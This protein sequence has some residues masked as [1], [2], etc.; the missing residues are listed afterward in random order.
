MKKGKLILKDGHSF[1][2]RIFG[3]EASSAGEV[4]FSTGMVGYPESLTDPSFEGQLLTLTYPLIGNYGIP[5]NQKDKFGIHNDFESSR[6]HIS[7]LVV[8][9]YSEE[10][11]HWQAKKS[12]SDYLKEAG[13]PGIT[14]IDTRALTKILREK[15]CMLGKIVVEDG[16][17]NYFDPNAENL[18]PRVSIAKKE[19]YEAGKKRLIVIDCGVKNNTLRH[20]LNRGITLIRVPWN[21]DFME[22]EEKFDGVFVSNGPGNPALL[23]ETVNIIR[24]CFAKKVPTFGICLGNQLMGLAAGAK[25]YKLKYGHR[26]QNQPCINTETGNCY[27]TSQN[28]GFA[29][30]RKTLPK[31]WKVWFE[32][33]NDKTVE[34]IKHS[35][36]PFMAVQFHPEACPGPVDTENLF[37][38]YI[39]IL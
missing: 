20:F 17:I 26:A 34:G 3:S 6:V 38:Q 27:M 29:I 4:V 32:Q 7:G 18:I 28:H 24:K 14:G 19:V 30:E 5:G 13:V 22:K 11:S 21:Y 16:D 15:G 25:T 23:T 8:S 35:K 12:L 39:N 9:E 31:E 1:E 2:G 10:Y 33:V 36:L 37:D